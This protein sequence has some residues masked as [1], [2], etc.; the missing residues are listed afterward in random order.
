MMAAVPMVAQRPQ[1]ACPVLLVSGDV[2]R[3]SIHLSFLNKSKA[4]VQQVSF[5]CSSPSRAQS[6]G[7][8]RDAICHTES[9]LFYPGTNYSINFAYAAVNRGSV[10]I[11]AKAVRLGNGTTWVSRP[12][13]SCRSLTIR[14]RK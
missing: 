1:V 13:V 7:D 14:R 10:L 9:G 6:R 3:D 4:P 5:G 8:S 12:S 2:D 11:S